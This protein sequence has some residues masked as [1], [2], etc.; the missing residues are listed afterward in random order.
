MYQV[1]IFVLKVKKKKPA[2][3]NFSDF[4]LRLMTQIK[5]KWQ[6]LIPY[7]HHTENLYC[8]GYQASINGI[9][10]YSFNKHLLSVYYVPS[11]FQLLDI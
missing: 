6:N 5:N 4:F 1:I 11:T 10:I 9:K 2:E 7:M 3:R 8:C